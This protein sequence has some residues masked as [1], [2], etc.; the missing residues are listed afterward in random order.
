MAGPERARDTFFL[1]SKLALKDVCARLQEEF[2]LPEFELESANENEWGV[3]T[4]AAAVVRVSRASSPD[5]FHDWNPA[6]PAGCNYSVEVVVLAE[7]PGDWNDAAKAG[8]RDAWAATL[9]ELTD[10]GVH[11]AATS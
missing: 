3:S 7:A 2:N 5:A 4:S 8:W 11:Q 1:E 6:C 9:G 10:G